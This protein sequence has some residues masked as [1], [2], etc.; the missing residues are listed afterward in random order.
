[1]GYGFDVWT[2][3]YLPS[4]CPCYG[5]EDRKV[6]CHGQCKKYKDWQESKPK[7]KKTGYLKDGYYK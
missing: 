6:G 7:I 3:N 4:K 2:F 1:M 5:C